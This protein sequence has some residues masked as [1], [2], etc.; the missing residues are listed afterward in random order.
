[1][2]RMAACL[3]QCLENRL[4]QLR[5]RHDNRAGEFEEE[6]KGALTGRRDRGREVREKEVKYKRMKRTERTW[7]LTDMIIDKGVY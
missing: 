6:G 3:L 7:W 2:G 5:W 4:G 1:M